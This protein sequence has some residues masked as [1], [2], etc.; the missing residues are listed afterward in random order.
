MSWHPDIPDFPAEKPHQLEKLERLP[1][2]IINA[3]T[4]LEVEEHI[5]DAALSLANVYHKKC[6][7]RRDFGYDECVLL[8]SEA[9]SQTGA[10]IEGKL[11]PLMVGESNGV[12]HMACRQYFPEEE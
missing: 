7:K 10:S 6:K 11:G 9:L 5:R 3:M 2:D 8:V 4:H 1:S 12:A